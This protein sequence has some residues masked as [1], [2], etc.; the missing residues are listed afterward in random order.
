MN[1]DKPMVVTT[2]VRNKTTE[3]VYLTSTI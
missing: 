3:Q 1:S 2:Q